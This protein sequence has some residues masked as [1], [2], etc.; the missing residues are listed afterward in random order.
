[1]SDERWQG[2]TAEELIKENL[3]PA[4]VICSTTIIGRCLPTVLKV[5]NAASQPEREV[6]I[7][8]DDAPHGKEISDETISN[9]VTALSAFL[10]VRQFGE[11]VLND[12]SATWWMICVAYGTAVV[13]S[14]PPF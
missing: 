11:R 10:E 6:L 14:V 13:A 4:W 5:D 9:A 12:L 3:C 1:M 7:K 2:K 8:A